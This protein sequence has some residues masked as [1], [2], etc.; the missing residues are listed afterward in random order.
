ML[1][2]CASSLTPRLGLS[3]WPAMLACT[4]TGGKCYLHMTSRYGLR[5]CNV[6]PL[7][8]SHENKIKLKNNGKQRLY[9]W[10]WKLLRYIAAEKKGCVYSPA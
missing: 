3:S 5:F 4:L 1:C 10:K 2:V 7:I 9:I 8:N 6:L